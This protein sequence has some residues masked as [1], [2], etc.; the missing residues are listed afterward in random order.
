V[1]VLVGGL[2]GAL[3]PVALGQGTGC[4]R[5]G[6]VGGASFRRTRPSCDARP[7]CATTVPSGEVRPRTEGAALAV[8][9][10]CAGR[11]RLMH[12]EVPVP[13]VGPRNSGE[14]E[15]TIVG[16]REYGQGVSSEPRRR[17]RGW[18]T[19][20]PF[21]V[22]QGEPGVRLRRGRS[23][24][25]H[26]TRTRRYALAPSPARLLAYPAV[27]PR[28]RG[29]PRAS[30]SVRLRATSERLLV[31]LP[32]RRPTRS[33]RRPPAR[34]SVSPSVRA[35]ISVPAQ[36]A[37]SSVGRAGRAP[38]TRRDDQPAHAATAAHRRSGR[39]P[40]HVKH[41]RIRRPAVPGRHHRAVP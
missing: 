4:L 33:L 36:P 13:G 29:F 14:G 28:T 22:E 38:P 26:P 16:F 2:C 3:D 41:G 10:S 6:A 37:R 12:R 20:P 18:S 27:S 40:F 15:V 9:A 7:G 21:H 32:A 39:H 11:R 19:P 25:G 8:C 23:G 34:P 31:C 5:G 35:C 30:I 1:I 17:H 24:R